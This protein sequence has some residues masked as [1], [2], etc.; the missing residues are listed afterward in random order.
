MENKL[1]YP[2]STTELR[3]VIENGTQKLQ[4]R[5]VNVT[6]GYCSKWENVP[7]VEISKD[8]QK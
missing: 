1:V 8:C 4:F 3:I 6:N 2:G 7:I 5:Y